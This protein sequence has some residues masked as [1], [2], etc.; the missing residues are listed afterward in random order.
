MIV[1]FLFL[2]QKFCV[3]AC[4]SVWRFIQTL[5][6]VLRAA[7]IC[8]SH[9]CASVG[10]V[11][12][13]AHV[14]HWL[15]APEATVRADAL[16]AAFL[17]IFRSSGEPPS[18]RVFFPRVPFGLVFHGVMSFG[19]PVEKCANAAVAEPELSAPGEAPVSRVLSVLLYHHT[20]ACIVSTSR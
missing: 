10:G 5:C 17:P 9:V 3:C 8:T 1:V 6:T 20:Y 16:P 18:L 11:D 4:V 15:P 13:V 7:G 12:G 14:H 2:G 19:G